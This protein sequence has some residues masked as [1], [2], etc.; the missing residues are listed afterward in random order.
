MNDEAPKGTVR[1]VIEVLKKQGTPEVQAAMEKPPTPPRHEIR[2]ETKR[3]QECVGR[4][5]EQL[6]AYGRLDARIK[7]EKLAIEQC[8][9]QMDR[10]LADLDGQLKKAADAIQQTRIQIGVEM[11]KVDAGFPLSQK[12]GEAKA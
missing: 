11:R 9:K 5:D 7:S 3:V 4:L 6:A 12:G 8:R 2:P 10:D 1:E